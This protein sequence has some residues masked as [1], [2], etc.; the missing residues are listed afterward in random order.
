MKMIPLRHTN[1]HNNTHLEPNTPLSSSSTV[2]SLFCSSFSRSL[3]SASSCQEETDSY[4]IITLHTLVHTD[5]F[6]AS[7][8]VGVLRGGEHSP[9][10]EVTCIACGLPLVLPAIC[11][12]QRSEYK[13]TAHLRALQWW[14]LAESWDLMSA[15]EQ[16]TR[17]VSRMGTILCITP[18]VKEERA[19]CQAA[20]TQ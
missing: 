13:W 11:A 18:K 19:C 10:G 6:S 5:L 17:G 4:Y 14:L 9:R 1:G 12:K 3:A 16:P 2:L 7:A 8:W 20:L 15:K